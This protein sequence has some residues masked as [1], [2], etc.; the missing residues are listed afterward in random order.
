MKNV[1]I[2]RLNKQTEPVFNLLSKSKEFSFYIALSPADF[3]RLVFKIM[4]QII[5]LNSD[6]VPDN[7]L[8]K[9]IFLTNPQASLYRILADKNNT[10]PVLVNLRSNIK[11]NLIDLEK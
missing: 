9:K 1:L 10:S 5:V 2:Y 7:R 8:L 6:Y 3:A 11:I 4:P